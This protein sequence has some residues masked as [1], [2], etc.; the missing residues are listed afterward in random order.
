[1]NEPSQSVNKKNVVL[2][3]L[4][5]FLKLPIKYFVHVYPIQV[6]KIKRGKLMN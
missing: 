1:M 4:E 6:S 3:P 5:I 2:E